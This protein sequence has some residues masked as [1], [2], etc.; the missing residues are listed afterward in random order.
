M[1]DIKAQP[2]TSTSP[3]NS[4]VPRILHF[5]LIST[6]P[7]MSISTSPVSVISVFLQNSSNPHFALDLSNWLTSKIKNNLGVCT[8]L[9]IL[10]STFFYWARAQQAYMKMIL[11]CKYWIFFTGIKSNS[12]YS[13]VECIPLVDHDSW[14]HKFSNYKYSHTHLKFNPK[15]LWQ[16]KTLKT[17]S[18]GFSP[19]IKLPSKSNW[20]LIPMLA[21]H[22]PYK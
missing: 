5:V 16:L 6:S 12:F 4:P 19:K 14:V 18:M 22:V 21:Y 20:S 17:Q 2:P 15:F 7:S 13:Q 10:S 8:I 11:W 3:N 9:E 1:D